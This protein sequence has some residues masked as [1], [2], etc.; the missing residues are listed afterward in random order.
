M[1]RPL[2]VQVEV[3]VCVCLCLFRGG[4]LFRMKETDASFTCLFPGFQSL[5]LLFYFKI[6]CL[7]IGQ[8]GRGEPAGAH[9]C[10]CNLFF[11]VQHQVGVQSTATALSRAHFP[12]LTENMK[13]LYQHQ[14][15]ETHRL[16]SRRWS[17]CM[18]ER[19]P[20]GTR[21]WDAPRLLA[22]RCQLWWLFGAV[23]S[24][25]SQDKPVVLR[26]QRKCSSWHLSW[27]T[28][29]GENRKLYYFRVCTY[30]YIDNMSNA[31]IWM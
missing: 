16:N 12:P 7:S 24:S 18:S 20:T 2:V 19:S 25:Q 28:E 1:S 29:T 21:D 11:L 6:G 27:F 23:P 26:G 9:A 4:D 22:H 3:V 14:P 30:V 31:C 8:W 13:Q 17:R 15:R 10:L 5:F